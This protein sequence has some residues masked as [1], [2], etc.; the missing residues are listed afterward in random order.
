MTDYTSGSVVLATVTGKLIITGQNLRLD[1]MAG[2]RIAI[3]GVIEAVRY[4]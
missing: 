4:G 1:Y 2:D 3:K